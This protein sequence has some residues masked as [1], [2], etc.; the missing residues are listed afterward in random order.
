M[1][2][3]IRI[4]RRP[5]RWVVRSSD[6]I[7]AETS[8][9]LEMEDGALAPILF[10]PR[11]DVAMAFLDA[12]GFENR[13]GGEAMRFSLVSASDTV[14]DVAWAYEATGPG[15]ERLDGYIT[16]NATKVTVEQL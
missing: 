1:P 13:R 4:R 12:S 9:A 5:G 3:D 11:S 10:F 7:L 16:F 15:T 14:A 6:A 2:A 8:D